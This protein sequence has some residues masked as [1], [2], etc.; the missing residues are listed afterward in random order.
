MILNSNVVNCNKERIVAYLMSDEKWDQQQ[1]THDDEK[2]MHEWDWN[3]VYG[4]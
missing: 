4:S 2:W 1:K 3:A